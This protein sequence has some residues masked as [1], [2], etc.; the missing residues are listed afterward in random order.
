MSLNDS[1]FGPPFNL[2]KTNS[3]Q[4]DFTVYSNIWGTDSSTG[5]PQSYNVRCHI[6]QMGSW[7]FLHMDECIHPA[8]PL[9]PINRKAILNNTEYWDWDV[10]PKD[11]I[12][13]NKWDYDKEVTGMPDRIH[14]KSL[15]PTNILTRSWSAREFPI[16]LDV[17]DIQN[18][19]SIDVESFTGTKKAVGKFVISDTGLMEIRGNDVFRA[20][21]A[22]RDAYGVDSRSEY[23]MVQSGE[24]IDCGLADDAYTKNGKVAGD[25][26]T[27]YYIGFQAFDL[28]FKM[29][30]LSYDTEV[31]KGYI[32]SDKVPTTSTPCSYVTLDGLNLNRIVDDINRENGDKQRCLQATIKHFKRIFTRYKQY[33]DSLSATD[34]ASVQNKFYQI[35]KTMVTTHCPAMNSYLEVTDYI[36]DPAQATAMEDDGDTD[37]S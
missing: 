22:R 14:F 25:P 31:T 16:M 26:T 23:L 29:T 37:M 1:L 5:E 21:K 33:Y 32:T 19:D 36:P 18:G 13:L 12:D 2:G 7:I 35:L 4:Y 9:K 10:T 8:H 11:Q 27:G 3:H 6:A 15:M 34:K 28:I 17:I 24:V 20:Y 30:G